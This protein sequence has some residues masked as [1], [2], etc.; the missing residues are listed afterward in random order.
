VAGLLALAA[1]SGVLVVSAAACE[2][3]GGPPSSPTTAEQY[4]FGANPGAPKV[5]K[6]MC[7]IAV[8]CATGND[9]EQQTDL[10]IGG[11]GPGLR[12]VRSYNA[13]A[14]AEAT[15]AGPWGYGWTG[16]YDASLVVSGETATVHQDNGSVVVFYK[17]GS[18]YT[19]GGWDEARLVKEGSNY[20]YTLPSQTKLEFNSEGRLTKETERRGNSNTF[21][22]NAGKQLETVTDGA[23]R[24]LTFKYNSEGLVESVEDPMKHVI[25][26]TY[27]SKNLAS[28]TIEGKT[29]WK[30]E[31]ES[32]HLLKKITDGRG[33]S[34]T[35]EYDSS[36]RV[37]AQTIAKH[38]R[39]WKYGSTPGTE[40]TLTE[41]SGL[42]AVEKFNTAG[43][44]T[45][46]TLQGANIET[47]STEYEYNATTYN[48]TKLIDPNKHETKYGYDSE[49]NLTSMVDPTKDETTWEYDKK[50]DIVKETTPEGE[51]TTIKRTSSGEPEVVE[52]P[53]GTETQKMEYKYNT[54]GD[55]K[56]IIDPLKHVTTFTYDTYGDLASE[57]DPE[58]NEQKWSDNKDSEVT[59]ETSPRGYV[60]TIERDERGLPTKITDP[61]KH[62]T[63]NEYNED[64]EIDSE[65]DGNNNTTKYEYNEEDLP[66][67]IEAPATKEEIGYDSEGQM[68][69]R[70]DGN[71]H[72]WEY[73]RNELE[74]VTEE[75][76]PL[77][78]V[79]K[80]KYEKTGELESVEDPEKH[81]TKYSY[82]ESNRPKKIEYSTGKPSEVT[83]EYNK[84][85]LVKKMIDG[86]GTTE[87]TWNKLDELEKYKNGAGK[88]VEYKYNLD[89]EPTTIVYPNGKSVTRA[90][91]NDGRLESVTDW[92]SN[93]T[94]FKYNAD[95]EPEKTI[96][97]AGTEN[98]DLYGYNEADQMTEVT[99]KG[100]L[101]ATLGKLVYE[102]DGDGQVKKT[103]TTTLPG[104]ASDTD[105]YD[106]D[107]R[108]VED[109]NQ[110][111][112][113]DKGDNPTKLEGAGPYKY[114]TA[115]E[116]EEGPEAKYAFNEDGQRS[117]LEPKSGEPATTYSYD[118]AGNLTSIERAK[119]TK[120]PEIKDSFTYDGSNLRQTQTINGTKAN[121][122]W[123]TT[124]GLPIILNDETN[125]YIYGPGDVPI[126][127]IPE[128]GETLYL[129]HDQQGSTRLLTNTKGKSEAEYTYNPYGTLNA[130]KGAATTPLRYDGQYTN[131]DTGLIYLRARTYDPGT[132][133][134][135]SN[136]PALETTGEPYTYA[137]DNPL[138]AGDASGELPGDGWQPPYGV[139][140][141]GGGNWQVPSSF[142][143]V[144]DYVAPGGTGCLSPLQDL[145][146]RLVSSG[147][148]PPDETP[149][150]FIRRQ[151]GEPV[152]FI[153]SPG[154]PSAPILGVYSRGDYTS[155]VLN[156][157]GLELG[158]FG[159]GGTGAYLLR[160]APVT[161]T[162]MVDL[163]ITAHGLAGWI[164]D[165][166]VVINFGVGVNAAHLYD[167]L[168]HFAH[169]WQ[170]L[171]PNVFIEFRWGSHR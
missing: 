164:H 29:Q 93:V 42:E 142:G 51:T 145:Y 83:F 38:E 167:A 123:D 128:T 112:E 1:F 6:V 48:V 76:N 86:T 106:G 61:L 125:N 67:K 94:S 107:N 84:D 113:Y 97:P 56:E 105:K 7:G 149:E 12:V 15:E 5:A 143:W 46:V 4:G 87:N 100:P 102:R 44:P 71:T 101:G 28:V 98:E 161:S 163:G 151:F 169:D 140:P 69:S 64:D 33:N 138:N 129:H 50:H 62:L 126:E 2:G 119:G 35:I 150:E 158:N 37:K 122:T 118:Q 53:A 57:T 9:A 25:S 54:T 8:D 30:F 96:F 82:D 26:Y 63:K 58:K 165:D 155:D 79:T 59:E 132:A 115:D 36:H 45:K 70:T 153:F 16:S 134:F 21:T 109:N 40:T 32:P 77:G 148:A 14:A 133:Q 78:K 72:T 75:K 152:G 170:S 117:K 156:F 34:V 22:Y 104:P 43:E 114:N 55:L 136:D 120:E 24:T 3:V 73:K 80:E 17:S 168:T 20:I 127:Q 111:Y 154:N 137:D 23:S 131:T 68:T 160:G 81:T 31:Y 144:A 90:Y 10:A 74:Q 66:T 13:L 89:N 146:E 65:T 11:R 99:M 91:D 139:F 60:T 135:L 88:T 166:H 121:L 116:L 27:S 147:N 39:K 157:L 92:N 124:E 103:T 159:H 41:P 171:A 141:Y 47:R 19:Q 18:E 49:G 52:R 110:A 85:S 130:S 108:L 95:S 162:M